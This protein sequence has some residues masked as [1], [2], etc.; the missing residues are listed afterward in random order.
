MSIWHVAGLILVVESIG[1]AWVW[2]LCRAAA[3]GDRRL[4]AAPP[5]PGANRPGPLLIGPL[6]LPHPPG[7]DILPVSSRGD[8]RAFTARPQTS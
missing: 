6:R 8:H 4:T 5:A 2:A 1:L 7:R 3:L